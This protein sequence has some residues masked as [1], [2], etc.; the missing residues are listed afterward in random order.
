MKPPFTG[1]E[2]DTLEALV[3]HGPLYDGDVPS[4]SGRDSLIDRGLAVQVVVR[5]EDGHTA[6]TY[7]GRDAWKALYPDLDGGPANTIREANL[8]RV[9]QRAIGRAKET[10]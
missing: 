2:R 10:R 8:N 9:T 6:A 4:K 5:G 1:A 7:D 3:L